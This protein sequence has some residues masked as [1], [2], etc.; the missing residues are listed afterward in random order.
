MRNDLVSVIIP[1]YN[2]GKYIEKCIESVL[3]QTY[4]NIEIIVV[5]DGSTDDTVE[6]VSRY[7]NI[8]LL[9]KENGGLCSARNHGVKFAKGKYLAFL[10]SD[11]FLDKDFILELYKRT[12]GR[13]DEL[14]MCDFLANGKKESEGCTFLEL[15]GTNQIMNLYLRGGIYNRTVNKLYPYELIKN[16]PFAT[17]KDMLEDAFFTAHILEHVNK[18]IRLPYAGYNYVRHEGTYTRNRLT[19]NQLSGM[20]SNILEKDV[21]LSKH[22]SSFEYEYL[23][24]NI[25]KHIRNCLNALKDINVYEIFEKI[26]YLLCFLKKNN[27]SNKQVILFVK[28]LSKGTDSKKL[29]RQFCLYSIFSDTFKNKYY[30]LRNLIRKI[31]R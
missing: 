31:I 10:D 21:V 24:R 19:V 3:S 20:H 17:G 7:K 4:Q 13:S 8:I 6:K 28:Y 27:S 29:K 5:N 22:V 1:A 16:I 14:V 2:S 26:K 18:I 30:Y 12:S 23:S 15:E 9:N 25:V 11:D